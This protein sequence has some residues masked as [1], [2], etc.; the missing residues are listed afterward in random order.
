VTK[1]DAYNTGH[2]EPNALNS[3][4]KQ[5]K[6]DKNNPG[7]KPSVMFWHFLSDSKG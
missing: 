5:A 2:I 3:I 1:A 4:L 7:W 6:T